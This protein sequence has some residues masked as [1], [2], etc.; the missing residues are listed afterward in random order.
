MNPHYLDR[1]KRAARIRAAV[2]EI[3]DAPN[4]DVERWNYECGGEH[5]HPDVGEYWLPEF[6]SVE[7]NMND[8]ATLRVLSRIMVEHGLKVHVTGPVSHSSDEHARL[9]LD[10]DA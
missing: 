7:G 1:E 10:G 3:R 8:M 9:V 2:E 6:V 5:F 4:L